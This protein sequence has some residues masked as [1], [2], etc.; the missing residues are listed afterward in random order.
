MVAVVLLVLALAN[1]GCS[2][3]GQGATH[4]PGQLAAYDI[5]PTPRERVRDGGTLHWPLPE[6]PSQWNFN[7]VNGTKGVVEHVIQGV[8]HRAILA[9]RGHPARRPFSFAD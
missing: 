2:A 1:A 6:F 3:T 4:V 9:R 8:R 5:N 7:H